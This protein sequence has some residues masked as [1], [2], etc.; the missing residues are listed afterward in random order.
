MFGDPVENRKGWRIFK[1][2][3]FICHLTSGGLGWS[4]YYSATGARFIRSF[5]VQM[6]ALSDNDTKYVNPPNNKETERT[7]IKH[8]DILLTITGSRI[9]RVVVM[10]NNIEE[11]YVSQH[12]AIIRV[13]NINQLYLSY[14]L[15]IPEG[16]QRIIQ[17]Q[18]YGQTK[19]GLSLEQL[20]NF[21]ILYPP[22]KL[23]NKFASIVEQVE[24]TKQKM[25]ASLDEM[26]NHFNALMQRYFG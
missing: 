24:Q 6:N 14:Y 21:S 17:R 7:R 3:E 23:Q 25:H 18:Q 13:K 2:N 16:G 20:K 10:P 15:S 9:G 8:M 19:P 4:K 26:D 22:I 1:L 12:V 5:D 11:A